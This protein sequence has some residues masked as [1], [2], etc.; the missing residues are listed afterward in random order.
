MPTVL[1]VDDARVDRLLVGRLLERHAGFEI[2]YATDG[3]EGLA[4]IDQEAPDLVV[5][6]LVMPVLD[7]LELVGAVRRKHPSV[8]VILMTSKGNEEIAV[9]ALQQGAASYVPKRL[10]PKRL[11]HTVQE[12]LVASRRQRRRVRLLGCMTRS[13][14]AFVLD[15]DS[16]LFEPL[17]VH[18]QEAVAHIGLCDEGERTR[19]GVALA[20]AL[21]NALYHGNL[22]VGSELRETDEPA[23]RALVEERARQ[24]PYR[25]RR[26]HV[27]ARLCRDEAV[28]V[29]RDDGRGFDPG[30]LPDPTD[31]ANLENVSGRGILLR[32]TFMDD[33]AF[34][35]VGN[36]VTLTKRRSPR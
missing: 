30:A 9:Q 21:S 34:N 28:F 19:I 33:V 8:P 13:D 4:A 10:V 18:L 22:E 31:P 11:V 1:V 15:N 36:Q 27:E 7:G 14:C 24:E 6:D 3:A 2:R 25:N 35:D 17:V 12:V 29:V 20:E 23:H 32:R 16:S 26:I 5:T